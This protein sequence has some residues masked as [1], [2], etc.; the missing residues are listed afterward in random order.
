MTA[1]DN[2]V[3][4]WIKPI[5]VEVM[6]LCPLKKKNILSKLHWSRLRYMYGHQKHQ[7]KMTLLQLR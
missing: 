1:C 7:L 4:A 5:K 3:L 2:Q 6:T